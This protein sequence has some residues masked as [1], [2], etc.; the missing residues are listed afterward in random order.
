MIGG[1][2]EAVQQGQTPIDSTIKNTQSEAVRQELDAPTID[3]VVSPQNEDVP[4]FS[5]LPFLVKKPSSET[6][7][8]L[9]S[10]E[11]KDP[12]A[13]GESS[14][15]EIKSSENTQ[16][17]QASSDKSSFSLPSTTEPDNLRKISTSSTVTEKNN[18]DSKKKSY[19]NSSAVRIQ[20][21]EKT[22]YDS[23]TSIGGIEANPITSGTTASC[24]GLLFTFLT[25]LLIAIILLTVLKPMWE[26]R[27]SISQRP[28]NWELN[29]VVPQ[30]HFSFHQTQT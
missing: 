5:L 4:E 26:N 25:L 28:H 21:I 15:C 14:L 29:S 12:S 23:R 10:G 22:E 13:L 8:P 20:N 9:K 3:S 6:V 16:N 27:K 30:K 19:I 1:D 7:V 17:A 18:T 2:V 11:F 24:L